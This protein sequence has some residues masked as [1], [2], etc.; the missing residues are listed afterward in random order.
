MGTSVGC[1]MPHGHIALASREP[2]L[3]AEHDK[4]AAKTKYADLLTTHH[5]VLIGIEIT[6]VVGPKALSFFKEIGCRLR[7]RSGEPLSFSH[8][9][10]QTGVTIQ[11]GNA[12]TVVSTNE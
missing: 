9:L 7:T 11:R 12:T 2:R 5:F 8:L 1:Y 10:Q 6:G 3:L 4:A